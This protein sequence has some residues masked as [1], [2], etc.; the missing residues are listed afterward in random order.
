MIERLNVKKNVRLLGVQWDGTNI[1][2]CVNFCRYCHFSDGW[3][4]IMFRENIIRLDKGDWIIAL[5]DKEFTVINN[6]TYQH[7]FDK[8][9]SVENGG[10]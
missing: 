5:T 7:L 9:K 8:Q 2:E 6:E 1:S 3:M 10:E 4:F